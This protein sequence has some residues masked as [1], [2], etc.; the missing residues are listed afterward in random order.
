MV[1]AGEPGDGCEASDDLMFDDCHGRFVYQPMESC[2]TVGTSKAS[3]ELGIGRP[4]RFN[5]SHPGYP[6]VV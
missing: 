3:I 6:V 2:T 4:P 1:G 5:P